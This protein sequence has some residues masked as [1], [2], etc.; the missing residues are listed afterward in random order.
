MLL[1]KYF[2]L[3]T[4]V[5]LNAL[6]ENT[7]I[8]SI[9]VVQLIPYTVARTRDTLLEI[10]EWRFLVQDPGEPSGNTW[11]EDREPQPLLTDSWAQGCVAVSQRKPT[12]PPQVRLTKLRGFLEI[13]L[14]YKFK[15]KDL[16]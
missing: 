15:L 13:S 7:I 9:F 5:A 6:F 3:V 14:F 11:K 1:T 16:C 8:F 2:C 4:S 10:L 12:P